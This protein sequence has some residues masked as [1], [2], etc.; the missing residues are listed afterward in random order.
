VN[1]LVYILHLQEPLLAT[2]PQS[3]EENSSTSF[4]FVPGSMVRGALIARYRRK[5]AD[6]NS[7]DPKSRG[8]R[9]FFQNGVRYLNAYPSPAG[10]RLLPR[11]LSW[12]VRKND[13]DNRESPIAD[14]AVRV[15]DALDNPKNPSGEFCYYQNSLAELYS[16]TRQVNVHNT[17]DDRNRKATTKSNVFRYEAL[18]AGELLMGVILAEQSDDAEQ[19]QSL[20]GEELL[21]GGSHSAGYGRVEVVSTTIKTEWQEYPYTKTFKDGIIVTL[22][23]DLIAGDARSL[24]QVIAKALGVIELTHQHERA[25]AK[26]RLVGSFNRKA[27]FPWIQQWAL[28]AGSVFVYAPNAFDVSL[29][30][31]LSGLGERTLDGFGRFAV[32]W[33]TQPIITQQPFTPAVKDEQT[34]T[35]SETSQSLA[36]AMAQRLLRARLDKKLTERVTSLSLSQMLPNK[37]QLSRVRTAA[38]QALARATDEAR[39]QP[40]KDITTLLNELK[41]SRQQFEGARIGSQTLL[42]WIEQRVSQRDVANQF[43]FN[44]E[45]KLP[46]V[47]GQRAEINDDL[48]TEYTARLI[49]GVMKKAIKQQ[50]AEEI[51]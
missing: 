1:A 16:P 35:L 28:Q 19:L 38:R 8:N 31:E 4:D 12:Q 23:S 25:Y 3:G 42:E 50:Q 49:D 13:A 29:L 15:D 2:Q 7:L 43:D 30:R 27:R 6:E 10:T 18:A 48:R 5:Y 47:A 33:H 44:D 14:F 37:A 51:R 9:L 34:V 20:F 40:L 36:R 41:R 24:D 17:S 26:L 39:P 32:N 46:M 21:L 22:L 45:S 11:P